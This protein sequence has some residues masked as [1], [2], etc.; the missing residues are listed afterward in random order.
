MYARTLPGALMLAACLGSTSAISSEID[1][2]ATCAPL[3]QPTEIASLKSV[4]ASYAYWRAIQRHKQKEAGFNIKALLPVGDAPIPL[5]ANG[6]FKAGQDYGDKLNVRWTYNESLAYLATYLPSE[7]G[8]QYNVCV[9]NVMSKWKEGVHI[10]VNEI[11]DGVAYFT[12]LV[13]AGNDRSD[14]SLTVGTNG[15]LLTI[16]DTTFGTGEERVYLNIRWPDPAKTLVLRTQLRSKSGA[17]IGEEDSIFIPPIIKESIIPER[18]SDKETVVQCGGKHNKG[19][20]WGNI[21]SIVAGNDEVILTDSI[22][23]ISEEEIIGLGHNGTKRVPPGDGGIKFTLLTPSRVEAKSYCKA[24]AHEKPGY[25][26]RIAATVVKFSAPQSTG[27]PMDYKEIR[28]N[29]L[30]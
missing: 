30:N 15:E 27:A 23:R 11:M 14:L 25:K 5:E 2:V 20:Y 4:S 24:N 9:A 18:I 19:L 7:L 1:V 13:R 6:S 8:E 28:T 22:R 17:S 10:V 16:P 3:I 29:L 26:G 12:L 21:T